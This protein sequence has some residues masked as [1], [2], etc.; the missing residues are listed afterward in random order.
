MGLPELLD[1]RPSRGRRAAPYDPSHYHAVSLPFEVSENFAAAI[2]DVG[3]WYPPPSIFLVA[4]FGWLDYPLAYGLWQLA[5]F[6]AMSGCIVL[7]ASRSKSRETRR[8]RLERIALPACM[9]LLLPATVYTLEYAQTNFFLLFAVLTFWNHR[10]ETS[11]ALA[12]ALGCVVKPIMAVFFLPVLLHRCWKVL[13]VAAAVLAGL[14]TTATLIWGTSIWPDYLGSRFRVPDWVYTE[15]VNQSLMAAVSRLWP[16]EAPLAHP[17]YLLAAL[18]LILANAW[19]IFRLRS[20][21]SR[22][23][24]LLTLL[25]GLLIYPG[26]L[27]HYMVMLLAPMLWLW[28]RRR[29]LPIHG[30]G[31]ATVLAATYALLAFRHGSLSLMATAGYWAAFFALGLRRVAGEVS[32]AVTV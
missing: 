16:H 28:H 19:L 12:L 7:L 22:L 20:T 5:S 25:T 26:T 3:F 4:P 9:V 2:L 23:P 30:A 17:I 10:S 27:N 1:R 11:G 29:R 31:L 6:A 15:S 18:A 21:R 8:Q 24:W 32:G 13:G 14:S